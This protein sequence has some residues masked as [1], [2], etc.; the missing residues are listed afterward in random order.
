MYGL[1]ITV[2]L[3]DPPLHEFL[4]HGEKAL[5]RLAQEMGVEPAVVAGPRR[6]AGRGQPHARP[7]RLPSR[8]DRPEIYEMQ[9]RGDRR[10]PPAPGR[11]RGRRS[12]PRSWCPLVGT[13]RGDGAPARARVVHASP[14]AG[15]RRRWRSRSLVGTMIEV[16]AG[17]AGSRKDRP[18]GRLLLLRH[19]RPH[20]D[21]LRLLARRLGPV[22]AAV[23]RVGRAAS[24]TPS[25]RIDEEGVGQLVR[26]A[27]EKGRAAR[28]HLQL[29]ICGEHGGDPAIHRL[30]RAGGARLRVLLALP[31]ADRAAGRGPGEPQAAVQ[32]EKGKELAGAAGGGRDSRDLSERG[33]L[34]DAG[35]DP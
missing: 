6:G 27:C 19:E 26:L 20:A 33:G 4:P 11:G 1:P 31:G 29:G 25:R 30:L 3:L 23:R 22:P 15:A 7:S 21:D 12:G 2:R 5:R 35:A 28:E 9:V 14:G 18:A 17:G 16:P 34:E 10:A 8:H 24:T 13:E 32:R